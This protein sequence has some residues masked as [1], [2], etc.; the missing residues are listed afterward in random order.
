MEFSKKQPALLYLDTNGFYFYEEGLPNVVSLAFAPTSVKDM[1]VIDST[2]LAAQ[3]KTFIEGYNI[4]PASITIIL[5]PHITFEKEVAE[6]KPEEKEEIV[7]RFVDTIPFESVLSRAYPFGKGIKIV[8]CNAEMFIEIKKSFE[9][10]LFSVDTVIPYQMLG[11]DQ[12]LI[13]NL[14]PDNVILFFKHLDKLR[15]L[16]LLTS[17]KEKL[18][19]VTTTVTTTKQ[20][21]STK[22]KTKKVRLY[23]MAG[24]FV[25]LFIILGIMLL[26]MK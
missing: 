24:I 22:P 8:G 9:T 16:T 12:T 20:V 5:S 18:Q 13:Q 6:V 15:Q 23:A 7:E 10:F 3:V 14:I 21:S 17:Q 1:D 4:Q 25:F 19:T 2:S 26:N 11:T